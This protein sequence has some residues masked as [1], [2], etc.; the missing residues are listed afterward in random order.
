LYILC[1]ERQNNSHL[2]LR[3]SLV[4]PHFIQ[5]N[6]LLSEDKSNEITEIFAFKKND[7][8]KPITVKPADACLFEDERNASQRCCYENIGSHHKRGF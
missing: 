5:H 3:R 8:I 2:L 1:S 4:L 6:L 7:V